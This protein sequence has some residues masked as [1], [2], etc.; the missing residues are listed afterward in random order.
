MWRPSLTHSWELCLHFSMWVCLPVMDTLFPGTAGDLDLFT[1]ME[2]PG[3]VRLGLLK[4]PITGTQ[5]HHAAPPASNVEPASSS[6][7]WDHRDSPSRR[8]PVTMAARSL[9][10][11]GQVGTWMWG[12]M[13]TDFT[14]RSML[15]AVSP[16]A[17]ICP[18]GSNVAEPLTLVFLMSVLTQKSA[19]LKEGGLA[20]MQAF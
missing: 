6:R 20:R 1:D 17:E 8:H 9:W 16:Q 13:Q 12:S 11:L 3:L 18:M 14:G 15:S 5:H 10:R 2:I 7:K 4:P 19:E